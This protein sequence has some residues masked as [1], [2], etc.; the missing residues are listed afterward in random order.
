MHSS[1][2]LLR[3]E[4]LSHYFNRSLYYLQALGGVNFRFALFGT[5]ATSSGTWAKYFLLGH[6][7]PWQCFTGITY[8]SVHK[9]NN[10]WCQ[11]KCNTAVLFCLFC[12]F[13]QRNSI[14]DWGNISSSI[15]LMQFRVWNSA[16]LDCWAISVFNQWSLV[17]S[18]KVLPYVIEFTAIYSER[19]VSQLG[20]LA[21]GCVIRVFMNIQCTRKTKGWISN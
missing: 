17:Y 1:F 11:Q 7:L 14:G 21:N 18:M 4:E 13:H 3:Y 9:K 10:K 16:V 8:F 15:S 20:D 12:A 5:S 19:C 6:L 2:S